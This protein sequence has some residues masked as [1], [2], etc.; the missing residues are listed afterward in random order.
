MLRAAFLVFL[1]LLPGALPLPAGAPESPT[2]PATNQK[3]PDFQ[4]T[5]LPQAAFLLTFTENLGQ[6]SRKDVRY[7]CAGSV[8]AYFTDTGIIYRAKEGP[9]RYRLFGLDFEGANP[10]GPEGTGLLSFRSNY[11]LGNEPSKWVTGARNYG[12]IVYRD[13]YD[14][15]DLSF[16]SCPAGLKYQFTVRPGGSPEQIKVRYEG[17]RIALHYGDLVVRSG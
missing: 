14:N 7:Y 16:K 15:I 6:L 12:G 4:D 1:L 3:E 13:L 17:A 2:P 10:V 8:S 11:F 9:D 5:N